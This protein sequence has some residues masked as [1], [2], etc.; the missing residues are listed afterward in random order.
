VDEDFWQIYAP[1]WLQNVN[2]LFLER[3]DPTALTPFPKPF[4][5][6]SAWPPNYPYEKDRIDWNDHQIEKSRR[7]PPRQ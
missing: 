3:D 5:T 1:T 7:W 6:R 2:M 4:P